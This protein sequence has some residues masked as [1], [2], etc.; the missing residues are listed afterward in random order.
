MNYKDIYNN[1]ISRSKSRTIE[2][3]TEKHH[4][5]PKCMGGQDTDD[6]I[7]N[8]T[9]EEHYVAHQLLVKMYPCNYQLV[10]AAMMMTRHTTKR[11]MN[12]KLFGWL[13]VRASKLTLGIPKS[14]ETKMKMR[15]PKS[16]A[17]REKISKVQLENG[18]NGPKKHTDET[19][20]K[21]SKSGKGQK[22]SIDTRIKLGLV[23]KG[24]KHPVKTCPHCGLTGGA[25]PMTRFHFENCKKKE[26]NYE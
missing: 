12:N 26:I 2:G 19:K 24:K 10:G 14:E 15:K 11:R 25:S 22:R 9:P 4:I 1:L 16:D 21:I 3:Y 5:V 7:V 18:G 13:R 23:H 20:A 6:N 17:H 8:L